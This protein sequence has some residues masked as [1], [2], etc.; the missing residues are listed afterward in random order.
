MKKFLSAILILI[1]LN[2]YSQEKEY[3][4]AS[5]SVDPVSSYKEK[6]LDIVGE[7]EY[8][9]FMY[10]KV[11]FESFSALYGGYTDIHSSLGWNH[12]TKFDNYRYYAGLRT[13]CVFRDGGYAINYGLEAG[14]D[15]NLNENFFVGIRTTLDYR[16]EQKVIFNWTPQIVPSG[17]IRFG[18]R[19]RL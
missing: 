8:S 4:T 13:A 18:Y 14:A 6:G 1:S 15:M 12:T 9:G 3:F 16:I 11:G 2:I 7:V 17:F 5:L 19:L 10:V